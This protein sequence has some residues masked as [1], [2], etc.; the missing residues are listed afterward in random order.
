[1]SE[2]LGYHC[3]TCGKFHGGLPFDYGYDAPYYWYTIPEGEREQRARLT[4]I[5]ITL[6]R[7]QEIA[8]YVL[9]K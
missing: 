1:M 6:S 3:Q 2:V 4:R 5:G 9:H 7:V 8:E